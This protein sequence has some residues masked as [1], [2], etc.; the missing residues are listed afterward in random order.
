MPGRDVQFPV[1]QLDVREVFLACVC[2]SA[3]V[4]PCIVGTGRI[5]CCR[6]SGTSTHIN[7]DRRSTD[8]TVIMLF[9]HTPHK[10]SPMLPCFHS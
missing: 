8:P 1:F 3:V 6:P 5:S 4:S 10:N 9:E 7:S 2:V